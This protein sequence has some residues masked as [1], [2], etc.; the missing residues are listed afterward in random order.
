MMLRADSG[1]DP[2]AL[3]DDLTLAYEGRVNPILLW[4]KHP[5]A[6]SVSAIAVLFLL[7]VLRRLLFGPRRTRMAYR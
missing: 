2:F 4:D 5:I 7:L 1:F 3:K 6:V